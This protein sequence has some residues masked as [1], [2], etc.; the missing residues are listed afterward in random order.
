MKN[1]A[2][3]ILE[4]LNRFY[5]GFQNKRVLKTMEEIEAN[6]DEQNIPSALL[7]GELNNK[8]T[9]SL[10]DDV[11]L[12]VEGSGANVKYYAQ[13]GADAAS[14]KRLGRSVLPLL[15][16]DYNG[17]WACMSFNVKDILKLDEFKLI[18]K[19]TGVYYQLTDSH[20]LVTDYATTTTSGFDN[21]FPV[22]IEADILS[23]CNGSTKK[24]LKIITVMMGYG[25]DHP[26]EISVC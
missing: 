20:G 8:L 11:K 7:L 9:S 19:A 15:G 10:P 25:A 26:F 23:I 4:G 21:Q 14:K 1:I 24:Y 16:L 22:N 5:V 3:Q 13:L 2:E 17:G 6:T 18:A 12:V